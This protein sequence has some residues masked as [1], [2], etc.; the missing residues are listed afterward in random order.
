MPIP[1]PITAAF[2]PLNKYFLIISAPFSIKKP[3]PSS[4]IGYVITSLVFISM[5]SLSFSGTAA[6]TKP[7]PLL[8]PAKED[9]KAAPVLP[10][11]PATTRRCP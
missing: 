1:G 3:L 7:A 11:L 2:L 8:K 4:H 9:I 5:I 10:E 6:V